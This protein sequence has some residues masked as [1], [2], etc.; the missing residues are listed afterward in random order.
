MNLAL[1]H[2][3]NTSCYNE[4][5]LILVCAELDPSET[6]AFSLKGTGISLIPWRTFYIVRVVEKASK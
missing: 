3:L 5:Y 6:K 1:L 2:S 4:N